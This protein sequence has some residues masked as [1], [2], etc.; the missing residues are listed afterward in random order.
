MKHISHW[1]STLGLHLTLMGSVV[2]MCG[3]AGVVTN[4]LNPPL[5]LN[6]FLDDEYVLDLDMDQN[7]VVDF[8]LFSSGGGGGGGVTLYLNWPARLVN[9]TNGV[10]GS[11]NIDYRGVA[12]LPFGTVL[13]SALAP[14]IGNY[15]WWTGFTNKYDLTQQYGDHEAGVLYAPVGLGD[16]GGKEGVMGVEF[17]I[18]GQIHYGYI[19]FDFRVARSYDGYGGYIYGWAYENTPNTP[20]T[21]ERLR[22]GPPVLDLKITYFAPWPTGDGVASLGW[23][24]VLGETNRVQ[25]SEDLFTWNDVS[26]NLVVTQDFMS[27]VTP[28]STAP[29]RFF[30]ISRGN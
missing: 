25:A 8:R 29:A 12:G 18:G 28:P 19:H 7:G 15:T 23:N 4:L 17:R 24:G 13:G 2:P 22:S 9:K 27:Y 5:V 10:S 20:I 30:R 1:V 16:V 3:T 26:T 11:T 14:G 6:P 21:A